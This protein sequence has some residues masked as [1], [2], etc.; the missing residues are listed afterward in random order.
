M[1]K[2]GIWLVIVA[3][4]GVALLPMAAAAEA[5]DFPMIAGVLRS[6]GDFPRLDTSEFGAALEGSLPSVVDLS[7]SLPPVGYQG[8]QNSCVGWAVGYYYKTLVEQQERGWDTTIPEHQF[9]PSYIYNQRDTSDCN[10]DVGMTYWDA[11]QTIMQGSA[12]LSAFPYDALDRCTQPST[13]VLKDSRA[14]RIESFANIFAGEGNAN[15]TALK[16]LLAEGH[17]FAVAVP[18]YTSLRTITAQNPVVPQPAP[19]E[20]YY[21]DHGL[22]VVGYDD[23]IGGF[24]V[25]N[26][27]GPFWGDNGFGYLSYG[28]MQNDAWEGWVMYDFIGTTFN[29]VVT[30]D[31]APVASGR[32]VTAWIGGQQVGITRTTAGSYSLDVPVD[33]DST[34]AQDG[35]AQGDTIQF[36]LDGV[37]LEQTAVW[38]PGMAGHLDLSANRYMDETAVWIAKYGLIA[39]GW[40]NQESYPRTMADVNGDGHAD[41]VGCGDKATLVSLSNGSGFEDSTS[42]INFYGPNAGG[43]Y[44]QDTYPRLLADVTGDGKADMVAFGHRGVQVAP[45]LGDRFGDRT[46]WIEA[47]GVGAGGWLSQDTY[48]RLLADVTGDGKDDIVAFGH[49]G[50]QVAPS[51]GNRFG[52]RTIWIDTFGV[53]AGGWTSQNLYPR[54]LGDVNGDGRADIVAFGQNSVIVSLSEG[55]RFGERSVWSNFYGASASA[56]KWVSQERNL[57]TL[58]DLNGD[59]R[60][61]II[62]FGDNAIYVSFST[63]TAFQ[64]PE[65]WYNNQFCPATGWAQQSVTPRFAADANGDGRAD[66]VGMGLY[67]TTLGVTR[68]V[69]ALRMAAASEPE[70]AAEQTLT[71]EPQPAQ[72]TAE[73]VAT[74]DPAPTAPR[75][76]REGAAQ[77][78]R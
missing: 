20:T 66:V 52:D 18:I 72:P 51:L 55:N 74:D 26:S 49:R 19:G 45:S 54:L 70:I 69:F 59:G 53:G 13:Q 35:A 22:L 47:Y 5:P 64:A 8:M 30:L 41:I 9:S 50:V 33:D 15:L 42:W 27:W 6:K 17:A 40:T 21:G 48:P 68:T 11:F 67:G 76:A 62:G 61:D 14:F 43:W 32:Q 71:V 10:A 57:R 25:V 77:A 2:T 4:L 36:Q 60:A 12:P 65:I 44:S 58:G 1:R 28:F 3:V 56:G 29:G 7:A 39:G 75:A 73:Q 16:Q 63:G 31:G 46:I 24:K 34:P 38:Q 23:Q 78:K 37:H